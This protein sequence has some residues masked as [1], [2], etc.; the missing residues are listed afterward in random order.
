VEPDVR[1]TIISIT[2]AL[3]LSLLCAEVQANSKTDVVILYNGDRITGEVKSLDGGM[4]SLSTDS[5]GTV[6]IEWQDIARVESKYFHEIRTSDGARYLGSIQPP[7]R[8]GQ[9]RLID[10]SG[11]HQFDALQVVG[12]RPI[13]DT[14]IDRLDLYFSAGYS[15]SRASDISQTSINTDI[16]YENEQSRNQLTGRANFTDSRDDSTQSSKLD[17]DRAVWT[18]RKNVFRSIFGNFETNDEL[19]LDSRIGAGMGLGRFFMDNSRNRLVGILGLQVIT[20]KNRSSGSDRN[21]EM[22]ISTRYLA[23]HFNTPELDLDFGLNLYPNLTDSGRWRSSSDL[24]LRWE[25]ISDLFFDITAYGTYDNKAD[26]NSGV[27]YGVTTGLGW[28]F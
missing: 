10:A 9:L 12:I 27:D 23:W 1:H 17:L 16:S 11:E 7:E 2:A 28:D 14:I 22:L 8:P 4:L 26:S 18:D 13:E 6:K 20:E 19:G 25:L 24:R 21:V 5:M 15:Y 3:L